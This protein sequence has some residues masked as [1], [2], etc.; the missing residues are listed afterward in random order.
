MNNP[1]IALGWVVWL[2]LVAVLAAGFG[3][4]IAGGAY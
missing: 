4:G 1:W 3:Y 2:M